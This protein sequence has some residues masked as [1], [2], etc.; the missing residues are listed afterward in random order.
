M[1]KSYLSLMV[2]ALLMFSGCS[3]QKKMESDDDFSVEATDG[4]SSANTGASN[5]LS[6]D[7]PD[8]PAKE[9]AAPKAAASGGDADSALES[10]LNSLDSKPAKSAEA[11]PAAPSGDELTLDDPAPAPAAPVAPPAQ[12]AAAPEEIPPPQEVAMAPETPA[13]N[14]PPS[15]VAATPVPSDSAPATINS[16]QYQANKNGGTI[17]IG[18]TQPLTYTTRLNSTTNQF[19][20]EVQNSQIPKKLKRSLNTKDMASSIGSVD[21]YQKDGSNISRFVVQLRPG[22]GEPIVQ[23][24]GNSLLII[25][26]GNAGT[27]PVPTTEIAAGKSGGESAPPSTAQQ[28]QGAAAGEEADGWMSQESAA[29]EPNAPKQMAL[30]T[31]TKKL[32]GT[33]EV[34][35]LATDGL[36]SY[37][38]L[39]DFLMS[40]SKFYGKKISIAT[41][42]MD[43]RDAIRFIAEESNINIIMDDSV[44]GRV[45]ISLREVPWDQAFVLLL[46]SKKLVYKRQG[47]VIRVATL[48]DI[49]KDEADAIAMKESRKVKEVLV[50]KRFFIGYAPIDEL[51]AKIKDYL[52]ITDIKDPKAP[53]DPNSA[54][55]KVISDKRT[56]SLIITD[57]AENMKRIETLLGILDTQPPQ[58]LIEGKVVEAVESFTRGMGIT[59]T[60]TGNTTALNSGRFT[61]T[62]TSASIGPPILASEF[63]WGQVDFLGSLTARLSLGEA[64]NKVKVL[65]S[66][67]ITVLSSESATI[68]STS[69]IQ[70]DKG[71][72]TVGGATSAIKETQNVGINLTVRPQASN[73]GTV[74]LDLN[75]SRSFA[76]AGAQ[77][78][79]RT[80]NTKVIVKSGQTSVIGGIYESTNTDVSSGVPGLRSV[81]VIG[82]LFQ[83]NTTSKDKSELLIFVTPTILKNIRGDETKQ[84]FIK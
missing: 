55:G 57:T 74:T 47:N 23:P 48:D 56:N 52:A 32:N 20:V 31:R 11:T 34:V 26:G 53:V 83:G 8:A 68:T 51:A 54:Q 62:P 61:I 9:S 6:L 50:V 71:T 80:A 36:M 81:P 2:A 21:I 37:D 19:I 10:E 14:P 84:S 82:A 33:N 63:T 22:A 78:F 13:A 70:I 76:G 30:S 38:N 39:E 79:S 66:P 43:I 40:N 73:E 4:G 29:A 1:K 24:E 60:S 15:T 35:D 67:R 75:I 41:D 58:I 42:N 45:N 65:S 28:E 27:A 64:E 49:K 77:T 46:K 18:S 16:V 72:T 17:S 25:G 3:S 7:T 12:A 59:W 44:N 5:D 69:S